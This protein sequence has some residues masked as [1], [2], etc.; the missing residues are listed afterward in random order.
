MSSEAIM[1]EVNRTLEKPYFRARAPEDIRSAVLSVL[2]SDQALV[3]LAVHVAG[4]AT[5]PEDDLVLATAASARADY[6]VTGDRQLLR[7]GSFEGMPVISPAD[8]LAVL[9]RDER[10][11]DE[12]IVP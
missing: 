2:H 8:F 9:D 7:L 10:H 5:H 3:P 1:A 11:S 12:P 4:V 6:L